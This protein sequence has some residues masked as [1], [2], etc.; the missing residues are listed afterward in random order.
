M[1]IL[2]T[3]LDML[4]GVLAERTA[5][6]EGADPHTAFG[7]AHEITATGYQVEAAEDLLR[8]RILRSMREDLGDAYQLGVE[9]KMGEESDLWDCSE[10]VED[11]FR[12]AGED[13]PDGARYQYEH[14]LPVVI[15]KPCDLGFLWSDKRGMIGHVFMFTDRGTVIH[16]VGGRGVVE[17]DAGRWL[18]HRRY[19]GARRHPVFLRPK[20]DRPEGPDGALD[21]P[22]LA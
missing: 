20:E 1:G 4:F 10:K 12:D 2:R 15:I 8:A 5:E 3:L 16:A 19:R 17:E 18:A 6:P 22:G 11:A 14:C 21:V 9:V 7:I 13:I